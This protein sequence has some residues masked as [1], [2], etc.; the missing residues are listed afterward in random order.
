MKYFLFPLLLVF[1]IAC[2]QKPAIPE[3]TVTKT[4]QAP[5]T[6][7][8]NLK[9][10]QQAISKDHMEQ[11]FKKI[12]TR[13]IS[14]QLGKDLSASSTDEALSTY[15]ESLREGV[16][17]FT[18][19]EKE[20][21][22][23]VFQKAYDLCKAINPAIY[24]D[25]LKL[26]K[27]DGRHYGAFTY[28]TR[29]KCIIIPKLQ[30]SEAS[31][32]SK[33][34]LSTMLHEIFHIYSRLNPEKRKELYALIGFDY[35]DEIEFPEVLKEKV[36]LNPDGL[37]LNVFMQLEN[38][39]GKSIKVIPVN[40]S[41]PVSFD[42]PSG[43]LFFSSLDFQLYEIQQKNTTFKVTT[44]NDGSTTLSLEQ[45]PD[46]FKQIGPNTDYII[47]PDEILADNFSYLAFYRENNAY[48]E[49]FEAVGLELIKRIGAVMEK[50]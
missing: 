40:Y 7:F 6:Y 8:L 38:Q 50:K 46:F 37:D 35:L 36:L 23:P 31:I 10:G 1:S 39:E 16:L 32:K 13:D 5:Q 43:D 14:L 48:G 33:G 47:H 41:K 17:E 22:V 29:E 26:L 19:E 11:F 21:L 30:L 27:T 34:F 12:N 18:K 28:Y 9:E 20:L 45:L 25:S 24:P 44:Q 2:R 4:S 15:K 42:N 3:N 49:K